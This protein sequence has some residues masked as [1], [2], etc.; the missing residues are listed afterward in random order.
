MARKIIVLNKVNFTDY[1]QLNYVFWLD[2]P[3][4]Q[5]T[6]RANPNATSVVTDVT[7]A[8]LASIKSGIITEVSG[9]ATYPNNTALNK[10]GSGLVIAYNQA[11]LD[12]ANVDQWKF[13][14]SFWDGSAWTIK[15]V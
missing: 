10:I 6:L 7:V 15:G 4:G 1:F 14:G 3:I 13:Y 11:Q 8:E 12:I 5:Q 2:T 9:N